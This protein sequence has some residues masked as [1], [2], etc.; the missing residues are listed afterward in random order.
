MVTL[1]TQIKVTFVLWPVSLFFLAAFEPIHDKPAEQIAKRICL[2]FHYDFLYVSCHSGKT[3]VDWKQ[4][5]F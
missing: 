3:F 2:K 4:P 5:W 1:R